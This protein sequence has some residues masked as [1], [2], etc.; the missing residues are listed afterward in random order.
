MP[1]DMSTA[2]IVRRLKQHEANTFPVIDK[3]DKAFGVKKI[4][5]MGTVDEVYERIA[6]EVASGFKQ[7]R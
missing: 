3:Y 6:A 5:G 2:N 7:I 4:D 1:Y